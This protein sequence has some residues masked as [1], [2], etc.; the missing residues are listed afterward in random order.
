MQSPENIVL[1]CLVEE[2]VNDDAQNDKPF[3]KI[4][5]S[6]EVFGNLRNLR[7]K[8][9]GRVIVATININSIRNKFEQLKYIIKDNIDILIITETKIDESFPEGQ[10]IIEG[11]IKPYRLYRNAHGG[12]ILLY[13]REDI[14]S[15]ELNKHTF[16]DDIE[17]IFV[18]INIVKMIYI[19]LI[20]LL[21]Q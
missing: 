10:F 12:G 6:D 16:P 7:I 11:F 3:D 17:G 2:E 20:L 1:D 21:K 19:T 13:V 18:E 4:P 15:K 9:I 14:P 5:N 8:N